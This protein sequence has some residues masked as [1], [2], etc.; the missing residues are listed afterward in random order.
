MVPLGGGQTINLPY[1]GDFD[2]ASSELDQQDMEQMEQFAQQLANKV[3][4]MKKA[5]E[6]QV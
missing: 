4:E 2:L 3:A 1:K 5:K 6:A